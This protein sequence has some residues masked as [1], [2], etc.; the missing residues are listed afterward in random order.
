M[1]QRFKAMGCRNNLIGGYPKRRA[2]RLVVRGRGFHEQRAKNRLYKLKS[3]FFRTSNRI[4]LPCADERKE[5]CDVITLILLGVSQKVAAQTVG[6]ITHTVNRENLA[7]A[8]AR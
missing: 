8:L 2:V 1:H 6:I 5:A 4:T 3:V 7:E